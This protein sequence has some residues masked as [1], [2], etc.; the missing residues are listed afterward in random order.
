MLGGIEYFGFIGLFLGPVIVSVAIALL[1]L[2]EE[3]QER[4]TQLP[5]GFEPAQLD[6]QSV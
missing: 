6:D 2:I 1:K 4:R 5:S 3:T